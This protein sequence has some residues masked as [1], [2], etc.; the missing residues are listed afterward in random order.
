M[1]GAGY[2]VPTR[3][4]DPMQELTDGDDA[5]ARSSS[6]SACS[7]VGLATPRSRSTSMSVSIRTA[8]RPRAARPSG[9]AARMSSTKPG[10][11]GGA[12]SISSRNRAAE[13]SR[14]FG[15]E[16]TATV[17]PLRVTSICSPLATRLSSSRSSARRQ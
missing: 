15:G 5:I 3:A 13:I 2:A 16:I 4:V 17:A 1:R 9:R 10:S 8:T 6:P 11:G 14:D 12:P 7:T